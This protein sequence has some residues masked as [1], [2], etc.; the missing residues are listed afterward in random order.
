TKIAM[1]HPVWNVAFL[2]LGV[3]AGQRPAPLL[4]TQPHHLDGETVIIGHPH[5]DSR[6]EP[7]VQERVTGGEFDRI[8]ILP[9]PQLGLSQQR[10]FM[11]EVA[12]LNTLII[13]GA[14]AGA[15]VLDLDA[16]A[17][18]GITFASAYLLGSYAV[19]T[20]RLR[21]D[22]RVVDLGLAFLPTAEDVPPDPV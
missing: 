8:M 1:I 18:A 12:V 10:S 19:P 9:R 6:G 2:R 22:P 7:E 11:K 21:Q 13:V 4:S 20:W 3:T 15:P 17:V 5:R 14:G 16:G